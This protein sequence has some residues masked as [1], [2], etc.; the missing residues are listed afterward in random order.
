MFPVAYALGR[1][2]YP[3]APLCTPA[4]WWIGV[5]EAVCNAPSEVVYF[6]DG[7]YPETIDGMGE[8]NGIGQG[9]EPTCS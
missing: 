2:H 3:V 4:E 9:T 7:L 8:S 6:D 1:T 5:G